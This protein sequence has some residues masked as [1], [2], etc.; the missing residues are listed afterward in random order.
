ME[1][2]SIV[3]SITAIII[4]IFALYQQKQSLRVSFLLPKLAKIIES[5][6]I[7]KIEPDINGNINEQQRE[8]TIGIYVAETMKEIRCYKHILNSIGLEKQVESL[9]DMQDQM[10]TVTSEKERKKVFFE[11]G[12]NLLG[13]FLP[14]L[15]KRYQLLLGLTK[16]Y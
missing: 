3:L 12:K 15:E 6:Q 5:S 11:L 13:V 1:I 4:S 14:A 7:I 10:D 16:R 9:L 2:I 8:I